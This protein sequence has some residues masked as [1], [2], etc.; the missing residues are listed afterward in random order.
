VP[1]RFSGDGAPSPARSLLR[2]IPRAIR[3]VLSS[4][5]RRDGLIHLIWVTKDRIRKMNRRFRRVRRITDVMAFR[6]E[7]GAGD[8]KRVDGDLFICPARAAENAKR[9]R[10][11]YPEELV[12]LSVHGTLH[13]LGYTDYV[14]AQRARMWRRQERTVRKI[15]KP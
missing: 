7:A 11:P 15:L 10:V 9:F 2:P 1:I 12:R 13:L 14:P 5:H 4:H 3:T 8:K 6:Y